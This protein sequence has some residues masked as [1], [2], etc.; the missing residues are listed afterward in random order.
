V[1]SLRPNG[2]HKRVLKLEQA[3]TGAPCP[4]CG[5]GDYTAGRPTYELLFDDEW[6]E[7]GEDI[8]DESVYCETCGELIWGVIEFK[9]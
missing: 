8:P 6:E 2:R 4:E 3:I 7:L 1:G 9:D 5:S